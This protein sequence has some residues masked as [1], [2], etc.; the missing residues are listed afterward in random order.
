MAPF[1][2]TAPGWSRFGSTFFLSVKC[3]KLRKTGNPK[4]TRKSRKMWRKTGK[5]SFF[6]RKAGKGPPITHPQYNTAHGLC[7][8]T[9][10][11]EFASLPIASLFIDLQVCSLQCQVTS[12]IFFNMKL[13]ISYGYVIYMI[14]YRRC[15]SFSESGA[16]SHFFSIVSTV[17]VGLET[18]FGRHWQLIPRITLHQSVLVVVVSL[19]WNRTP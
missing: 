12:C 8:A 5:S 9:F 1:S 7:L 15:H 4:K 10:V 17:N 11:L 2:K 13:S 6:L 19:D 18:S 16:A 3:E 14:L